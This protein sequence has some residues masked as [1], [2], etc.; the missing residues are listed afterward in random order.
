M[1]PLNEEQI[2]R[3]SCFHSAAIRVSTEQSHQLPYI[4]GPLQLAS[5]GGEAVQHVVLA[6]TEDPLPPRRHHTRHKVTTLA[7][8]RRQGAH[9]LTLGGAV[10][11]NT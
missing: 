11:E 3:I 8:T 1:H 7:L 9:S 6:N 5:G 2:A 10:M 4:E